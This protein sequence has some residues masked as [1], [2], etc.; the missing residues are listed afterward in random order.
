M[1]TK[2]M[3]KLYVSNGYLDANLSVATL[4]ELK[5]KYDFDGQSIHM[6]VAFKSADPIDFWMVPNGNGD[7]KWEIKNI[8]SFNDENDA[9]LF[10][11]FINKFKQ[12]LNYFPISNGNKILINGE[13]YE[14]IIGEDGNI[15][16]VSTQDIFDTTISDAVDEAV[17]EAVEKIT[18][19]ASSA[20]DTLKEI[21]DWISNNTF[22]PNEFAKQEDL[23]WLP[24]EGAEEKHIVRHWRGTRDKYKLLVKN[25]AV[26][27]W[28]KYVVMD[29]DVITEYYGT[30][31]VTALTGQLLP[32]NSI[33]SNISEITTANPYDRY[34]VGA[35]GSGYQIYECVFDSDDILKWHIKAFDYRYG[36]RVKD[37]GLKNY[38][39]VN[40]KLITYDDVDCGT[41]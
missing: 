19:G 41:F 36:V 26:N 31:Q 12:E 27:D 17:G 20:F 39:Y 25:N 23:M 34:L 13:E 11:T 29:G 22:N 18:S 28:T 9:E 8:P 30:N 15:E 35:D 16:W 1:A 3:D 37:K 6:P 7:I 24:V 38:I 5:V 4:E 10:K 33:I 21:E 14:I 40:E 32:V 2:L